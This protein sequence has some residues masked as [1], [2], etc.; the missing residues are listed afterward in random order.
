MSSPIADGVLA[1]THKLVQQA[2]TG[3]W[4]D[5]PRTV[6][7]RRGL[8]E[9]VAASAGPQDQSWL[10][11]LKQAMAESDA[12]VAKMTQVNGGM[13]AGFVGAPQQTSAADPDPHAQTDVIANVIDMIAPRAPVNPEPAAPAYD[14]SATDVIGVAQNLVIPRP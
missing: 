4:Q 2:M 9:R 14:P 11:A 5:V 3:Q 6:E 8:L 13:E 1:A 10:N 12:V 7:E